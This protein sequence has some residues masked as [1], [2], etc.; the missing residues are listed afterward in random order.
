[1]N[2]EEVL[3]A[4][5]DERRKQDEKWGIQDYHPSLP[6]ILIGSPATTVADW[7][8]IQTARA[9]K[10]R[11]DAQAKM[12]Q[13]NFACILLE[14]VAEAIEAAANGNDTAL[15]IELIQVAAT[16][17]KWIERMTDEDRPEDPEE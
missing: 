3:L 10:L 15:K 17:V 13:A 5:A 2:L 9:A 8:G 7:L 14:E 4:V 11:V 16:A 1:M 12:G 6:T